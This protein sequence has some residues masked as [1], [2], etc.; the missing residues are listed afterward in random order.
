MAVRAAIREIASFTPQKPKYD[1][2]FF[3]ALIAEIAAAEALPDEDFRAADVTHLRIQLQEKA[4]EC[5]N[6]WQFL[7]GYIEDADALK[8]AQQ[9]PS[10]EAAGSNKYTAASGFDWESVTSIMASGKLFITTASVELSANNNMPPAFPAAW[11][12]VSDNFQLILQKFQDQEEL[13]LLDTQTKAE[14]NNTIYGKIIQICKDGQRIFRSDD[15]KQKQFI[16]EQILFLIRGVGIAGIRGTVTNSLTS[17]TITGAEIT[18]TETGDKGITGPEGIYRI[19][20][21]PAGEY[22]VECKATGYIGFAGSFKILT[23]TISM[24]N[25]TLAP[26]P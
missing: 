19:T 24:L 12:T 11:D 1:L 18:I 16:W 8:G 3:N 6:T 22:K 7:K 21:V 17:E 23:G 2:L 15:A 10:L 20:G 13:K 26:A 5:L 25:I 14:A 4:T 9:K